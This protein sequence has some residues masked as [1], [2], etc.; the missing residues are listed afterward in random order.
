MAFL[1]TAPT[2]ATLPVAEMS[3]VRTH[4]VGM[5]RQHWRSSPSSSACR[6]SPPSPRWPPRG[7]SGSSSTR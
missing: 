6:P 7:S 3:S 2:A 1:M 5:L 4:T